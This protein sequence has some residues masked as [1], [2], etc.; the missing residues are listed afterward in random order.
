[1]EVTHNA[2]NLVKMPGGAGT[3][4]TV[5]CDKVEAVRSLRQACKGAAPV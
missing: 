1:M 5:C 4:I 3:T 2:Y